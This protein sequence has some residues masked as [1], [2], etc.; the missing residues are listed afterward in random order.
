MANQVDTRRTMTTRHAPM[1]EYTSQT[2]RVAS[3][4]EATTTLSAPPRRGRRCPRADTGRPSIGRSGCRRPA[5]PAGCRRETSAAPAPPAGNSPAPA[6]SRECR[7]DGVRPSQTPQPPATG[8]GSM[9][10]GDSSFRCSRKASGP[11]GAP[12]G[13]RNAQRVIWGPPPPRLGDHRHLVVFNMKHLGQG[14]VLAKYC[15]LVGSAAKGAVCG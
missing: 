5:G 9:R 14:Q 6:A 2:S 12:C 11:S 15:H 4:S 3:L 8:N 1:Y 7:D 10:R 13:G